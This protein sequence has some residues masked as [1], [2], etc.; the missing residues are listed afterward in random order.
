MS[1]LSAAYVSSKSLIELQSEL[2]GMS[3][4]LHELYETLWGNLN[5]LGEEWTDEKMEEFNEEFET[6]RE[7]IVELSEKYKE[8]A[9]SY[10][11]PR[12]EIAIEYEKAGVGI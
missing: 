9:D 11:P 3:Q 5:V 10:L 6:T 8:W 2:R 7:T 4:T 1:S 12:I